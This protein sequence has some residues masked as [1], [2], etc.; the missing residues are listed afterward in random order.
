[1]TTTLSQNRARKNRADGPLIL[2]RRWL[3][4]YRAW[5]TEQ[6]AIARLHAMSDRLLGDIGLTRSE[7]AGAVKYKVGSDAAYRR[8]M[9][10]RSRG[11]P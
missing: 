11:G 9:P 7:I 4:A 3:M 1:M 8:P 5:R 10:R 2:I 6:I